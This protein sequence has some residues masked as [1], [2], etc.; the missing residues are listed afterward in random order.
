METTERRRA[1][2]KLLCRRRFDTVENMAL[3]LGVSKRTIRRDIEILS[4]SE[5]IYTQSGRGGGVYIMD[6]YSMDRMY[7]SDETSS[8][9]KKLLVAV[10]A[11]KACSL[12]GRE[13]EIF[14]AM[15]AEYTKPQ[16]KP[17]KKF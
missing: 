4:L 17:K 5:P 2:I 15:I 7:V 3:E 8:V 13:L 14:K 16:I 11:G 10:Q 1:I 9:L 6:N 12:T